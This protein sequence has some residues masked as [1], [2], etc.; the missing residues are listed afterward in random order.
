MTH[1]ER[2][3]KWLEEEGLFHTSGIGNLTTSLASQFAEVE[4]VAIE[5]I[6]LLEANLI[7]VQNVVAWT[8][9]C[10]DSITVIDSEHRELI[11]ECIAA[12]RARY[13][14]DDTRIA[15]LERQLLAEQEGNRK[16]DGYITQQKVRIAQLEAALERCE[17]FVELVR[18]DGAF[19]SATGAGQRNLCIA[20]GK[21]QH[22]HSDNCMVDDLVQA[23]ARAKVKP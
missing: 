22:H 5:R 10:L 15:Q 1:E 11:D 12:E 16:L 2:A 14:A 19:N 13:E 20:C 9:K 17:A 23:I 3:R 6:R 18:W 7:G 4:K 8:C 21:V